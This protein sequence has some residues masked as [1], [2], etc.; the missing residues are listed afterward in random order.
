MSPI[1]LTAQLRFTTMQAIEVKG[2]VNE[3][4]QISLDKPLTV[5]LPIRKEPHPQSLPKASGRGD[6]A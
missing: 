4:G 5:K 1:L 6:K 3:L 2:T